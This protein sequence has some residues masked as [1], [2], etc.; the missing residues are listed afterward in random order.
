MTTIYTTAP[1]APATAFGGFTRALGNLANGLAAYW[2]R[3]EAIKALR[4]MNDRELRDIGIHRSHIDE[5]VWG[6]PDPEFG[7]R[8]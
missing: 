4:A 3:R 6:R 7:R 1:T 5:A 8:G 2:V